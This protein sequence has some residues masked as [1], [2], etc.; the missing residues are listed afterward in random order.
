MA[1]LIAK[2]LYRHK[3][4]FA[5]IVCLLLASSLL[6]YF[7]SE[8]RLPREERIARQLAKSAVRQRGW[9]FFYVNAAARTTNGWRIHLER[10][11]PTLGGHATVE[12][13]D[14][15]VQKYFKGK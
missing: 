9:I 3:R 8:L 4:R 7:V 6:A 2:G 5:L 14:G 10:L 13:V 1:S 15:K 12:V 11:P